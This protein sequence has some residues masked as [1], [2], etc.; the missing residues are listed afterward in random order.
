HAGTQDYRQHRA[1]CGVR[2]LRGDDCPARRARGARVGQEVRELISPLFGTRAKRRSE[3]VRELIS[4]LF[5]TRTVTAAYAACREGWLRPRPCA[6]FW[7]RSPAPVSA[8]PQT[9]LIRAG[10]FPETPQRPWSSA[11][12]SPQSRS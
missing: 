3:E 10:A 8:F 11:Y 4:P 6:A 7:Q 9:R 5:G 2:G 1:R 12:G